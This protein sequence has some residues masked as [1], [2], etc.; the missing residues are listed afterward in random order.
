MVRVLTN[1]Q[2]VIMTR[3]RLEQ[4][5]TIQMT[6][7]IKTRKMLHPISLVRPNHLPEK[8]VKLSLGFLSCPQS[9]Q[10]K[11]NQNQRTKVL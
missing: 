9:P 11:A 6:T 2:K 5:K 1:Q 3:K 8:R 7:K 10:Q 4:A